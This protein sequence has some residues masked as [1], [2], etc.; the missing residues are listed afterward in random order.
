MNYIF[1]DTSRL[2]PYD[3]FDDLMPLSL[4]NISRLKE[5]DIIFVTKAW[6]PL[7]EYIWQLERRPLILQFADGLVT[8]KNCKKLINSV[9]H[10]LY[11][12]IYADAF[13][14]RQPKESLPNFIDSRIVK[15]TIKFTQEVEELVFKAIVLVFGNDP[16][17]GHSEADLPIALRDLANR[18]DSS[19]PVFYSSPSRR[20]NL[21]VSKI[22]SGS[23]EIGKFS[24]QKLK[25]KDALMVMTPS[26]VGYDFCLEGS[27]VVCLAGCECP[28]ISKLFAS[29]N[30]IRKSKARGRVIATVFKYKN[31]KR[32]E[33]ELIEKRHA[34]TKPAKI[35]LL[36][37]KRWLG[38]LGTLVKS[39]FQLKISE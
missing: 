14:V 15:S 24:D 4:L 20:I 11:E 28:T 36:V 26:T 29:S 1:G 16:Y 22:F 37:M 32:F 7:I 38:D 17:V 23:I 5:H 8:E 13:Y 10:F 6:S 2:S 30:N 33:P 12:Q 3:V 9:P 35:S 25:F 19:V 39:A 21:L 18:I 31:V 34:L 27:S